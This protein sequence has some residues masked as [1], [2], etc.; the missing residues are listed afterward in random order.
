MAQ[1]PNASKQRRWLALIQLWQESQPKVTI[2]EFCELHSL[3]EPCFFFWRRT[4]RQ[5]GLLDDL[6]PPQPS[7]LTPQPEAPAFLQLTADAEP[8]TPSPIDLVLNEQRLLRVRP[9]FD[10]D[11]LLQLVRLLE[12]PPC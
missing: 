4:L 6:P 10:A 1:H 9:G 3:S 2:R 11:T 12:E 5:R 8:A 7:K